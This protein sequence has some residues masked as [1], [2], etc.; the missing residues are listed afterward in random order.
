[1][2]NCKVF[3]SPLKWIGVL[4]TTPRIGLKCNANYGLKYFQKFEKQL[5]N[6]SLKFGSLKKILFMKRLEDFSI[7]FPGIFQQQKLQINKSTTKVST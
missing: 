5:H 3:C 6:L 2:H 4:S 1:M 7:Q